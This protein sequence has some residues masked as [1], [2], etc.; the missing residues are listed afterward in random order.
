MIHDSAFFPSNFGISNLIR[1][2]GSSVYAGAAGATEACLGGVIAEV[3]AGA[4]GA[5]I[6]GV[7]VAA[8]LAA[9]GCNDWKLPARIVKLCCICWRPL[10]CCISNAARLISG[11]ALSC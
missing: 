3:A 9:R 8:Q 11:C 5:C 10:D 7:G 6:G 4:T 1:L 2:H